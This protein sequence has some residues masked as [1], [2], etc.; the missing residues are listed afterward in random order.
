MVWMGDITLQEIGRS[1]SHAG[2]YV[3][4]YMMKMSE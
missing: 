4:L 2:M 3:G 1:P